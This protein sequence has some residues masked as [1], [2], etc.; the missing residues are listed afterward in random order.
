MKN[1]RRADL[2][3]LALLATGCVVIPTSLKAVGNPDSANITKL[4]ADTKAVAVQLKTDSA[5]MDS[6]TRSNLS[7]QGYASKLT[8]IKEHINNAGQLVAK[9]KTAESTGSPWQQT[10]IKQIEPLLQEMADNLTAT[11][12]HLN[13]NQTRVHL[14]AFTDYVKGNYALAIDLEAL[15][16]ASVDY[17]NDK[18]KFERLSSE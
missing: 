11:I 9:L 7:W 15:V 1:Y 16:R 17:G 14:P 5:Q 3:I 2:V 4:L 18:A 10:A 13:A 12:K 6:F 8:T